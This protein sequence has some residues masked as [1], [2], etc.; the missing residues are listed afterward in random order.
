MSGK[1]TEMIVKDQQVQQEKSKTGESK[2]EERGRKG[3]GSKSSKLLT[4]EEVA[5][6]LRIKAKTVLDWAEKGY[7]PCI[8]LGPGSRKLVRFKEDEILTLLAQNEHCPHEPKQTNPEV[9]KG[10]TSLGLLNE[11]TK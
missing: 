6:I 4:A 3:L 9:D 1:I 8:T 11:L 5:E 10:I 2:F 7:L